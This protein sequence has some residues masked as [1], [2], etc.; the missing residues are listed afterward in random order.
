MAGTYYCSCFPNYY[1]SYDNGSPNERK[2]HPLIFNFFN[3]QRDPTVNSEKDWVFPISDMEALLRYT[4]TGSPGLTSDLFRLSP[5]NFSS[6]AGTLNSLTT[7]SFALDRAAVTPWAWNPNSEQQYVMNNDPLG[8]AQPSGPA[9]PFQTVPNPPQP[10]IPSPPVG[11]E[12]SGTDPNNNPITAGW[13]AVSA[14][15]TRVDLNRQLTPYPVGADNPVDG[16]SVDVN[17]DSN[18]VI[19]AQYTRAH[20]ERKQFA[21]DI[22]MRLVVATGAYNPWQNQTP[23]SDGQIL[24]LRWLAQLAVNI[25]DYIDSDDIMTPFDWGSY[26][27]S[28]FKT[29]V[30]GKPGLTVW[31]T[32]LPRV[33]LNEAY[34]E[35]KPHTSGSTSQYDLDFWIELYN[36]RQQEPLL[37]DPRKGSASL[38]MP[39][40]PTAV[41]DTLYRVEIA[42]PDATIS[43]IGVLRD[44]GNVVGSVTANAIR[45]RIGGGT[46]SPPGRPDDFTGRP[47]ESVI[48]PSPALQGAAGGIY[49]GRTQ[50]PNNNQ[51]F[52]VL[53]PADPVEFPHDGDIMNSTTYPIATHKRPQLHYTLNVPNGTS[54]TT[55]NSN[56]KPTILLRRLANP[57]RNESGDNPYVTVDYMETV[58]MNNANPY[59]MG[60]PG[61]A[62]RNRKSS[63]R[64]SPY[65]GE[66]SYRTDTPSAPPPP[67]DNQPK[68]SLFR[69]NS[70]SLPGTAPSQEIL[71]LPLEWVVHLDRQLI[72]PLELLNVSAYKPH[73]LT[74]QFHLP[75]GLGGLYYGQRAPWFDQQA[76][77]YRA[78]ELLET[79]NRGSGNAVGARIPGR[80]NINTVWEGPIFRALC[81]PRTTDPGAPPSGFTYVFSSQDVDTS[82]TQMLAL[83]SGGGDPLILTG[84][85]R[86]FQSTATGYSMMAPGGGIDAQHPGRGIGINDTLLRAADPNA[87][88]AADGGKTKPRL[89]QAFDASF[90]EPNA[91]KYVNPYFKE[92]MLNKLFNNVTTRSNV[93]AVWVTVG[94]F[95][96]VDDTTLPVKLGAEIGKAENRH[97][98]HRMFAIVDRSNLTQDPQNIHQ[99]GGPPIFLSAQFLRMDTTLN[100]PVCSIDGA[101][102]TLGKDEFGYDAVVGSYEGI[103][104]AITAQGPNRNVYLDYGM[105]PAAGGRYQPQSIAIF[106]VRAAAGNDPP[107]IVLDAPGL[108]N[109]PI[110]PNPF[111]IMAPYRA[112]GFW[113]GN[114]GPQ[115]R[116]NPR[117]YPWLVRHFSVIN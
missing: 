106:Q 72:S 87:D 100:R 108:F 36:P 48:L 1:K 93:F 63:A 10:V 31:G 24:A 112:K 8:R 103:P 32:E 40:G 60:D 113:L 96:V 74:Q 94:F 62:V 15:L 58:N 65:A 25:V 67:E 64:T 41:S 51:P 89:F 28:I 57:Y 6:V 3:P 79:R 13:Q 17:F 116:F 95:K 101:S 105:D 75:S 114:P 59:M 30:A 19:R 82:Y 4:E 23:P 81:D 104:W 71:Q 77:L 78:F 16:M 18:P 22:Y 12:Y 38:R 27:S 91:L 115:Q 5:Q 7:H 42:Q 90:N 85:E 107:T 46:L 97:V 43:S 110:H 29:A 55:F 11:S 50:P 98:R 2:N 76:R 84:N 88:Q 52:Y 33:L 54:G 68:H 34:I 39:A 117:E 69:H 102:P 109:T 49:S 47:D 26:G 14:A 20:E 66:K 92:Q 61:I 21:R 80:V 83:R 37:A 53:G 44:P 45:A 111:S 70:K 99:P 56:Y 73:E 35:Y 86:P 9:I